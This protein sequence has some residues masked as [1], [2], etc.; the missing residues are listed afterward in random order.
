MKMFFFTSSH[1]DREWYQG[2]QGFRKRLVETVDA[3][4]HV[5]KEDTDYKTQHLDG[6]TILLE[7]VLDVRPD[8]RNDL[9]QLI[10]EKRLIIGPWYVMPDEFLVSG[11]ALIR[12]LM[13]GH[14]T[15]SEWRTDAWKFGYVCD[16]FGHIAQMPQIMRGFDIPSMLIWR[17]ANDSTTPPYFRWQAPNGSETIV[18]RIGDEWAYGAFWHSTYSSYEDELMPEDEFKAKAKGCID[19]ELERTDGF[20]CL[21]LMNGHDHAP[22]NRN[23]PTYI[24]WI[25]ELYPEAEVV[26]GNLEAMGQLLEGEKPRMEVRRGEFIE[27]AEKLEGHLALITNTV[28]SYYP[29]KKSNDECQILLER[30]AGP[31]TALQHLSGDSTLNPFYD[32]AWKWLIKNQPHDSICGCSIDRVH[33]D[34]VYRFNQTRDIV[35]EI[36]DHFE[37][38]DRRRIGKAEVGDKM[39]AV[40]DAEN[41][42]GSGTCNGHNEKQAGAGDDVDLLLRIFNPLPFR[43]KETVN[44]TVSFPQAYSTRFSEPFHY[45]HK[46]CFTLV[47]EN[48]NEIP[49]TITKIDHGSK[50]RM[51]KAACAVRDEYHVT[52]S[53]DLRP[54]GWT[55]FTVKPSQKPVRYPGTL[56]TGALRADN[57]L[58]AL[59]ILSDGTFKVTDKRTGRNYEGLNRFVCDG[60]IGDG[61]FHENPIGDVAVYSAG[62]SGKIACIED[63][64][65]RVM[66]IIERTLLVPEELLYQGTIEERYR[67]TR[68]SEHRVELPIST[69]IGLTKNSPLVTMNIEVENCAGDHRLRMIIPTGICSDSYF[70][71]QTFTFLQRPCG[72]M[73]GEKTADWKELEPIEKNF[74]GIVGKRDSDG[75][76]LAFFSAA[77]LHEAAAPIDEDGSLFVTLFRSFRRTVMTNGE[78]GGQLQGRL[79]FRTGLHYFTNQDDYS[80]IY[81]RYLFFTTP[82]HSYTIDASL[83][84]YPVDGRRDESLFRLDEGPVT[85]S[86]MKPPENGRENC[87]VVR[88]INHS[89]KASPTTLSFPVS[90]KVKAVEE[91][92]LNEKPVDNPRNIEITVKRVTHYQVP[93]DENTVTFTV[94]AWELVT[95]LLELE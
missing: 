11:E 12:N 37:T 48:G 40:H 50:K 49:Y 73:W 16:I 95:L 13:L 18:V 22:I 36:R 66:F 63:G 62:A 33:E 82:I 35:G 5:M 29:L 64:P 56:R 10:D 89:E 77:G 53:S 27:P 45:Q 57:G 1:W 26:H 28:S 65:D 59:E 20:P 46:N 3:L 52:F 31:M 54:T 7:D 32:L 24:S 80:S 21:V 51:Y 42:A 30:T 43:R 78:T 90:R 75:A 60:E 14:R 85:L 91:L 68:P 47:D 74:N 87:F 81:S 67:G 6:Q 44:C 61:W 15:A 4:V 23:V 94:G 34:M 41:R 86:T 2:F 71:Y 39:L 72:R 76:G 79:Q 17:G 92:N 69:T 19:R 55:T 93:Q 58:L 70:A 9:Q 84:T 88:V 8:L 25:G 83:T 38:R